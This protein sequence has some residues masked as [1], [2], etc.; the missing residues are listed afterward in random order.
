MGS[1][2]CTHE[3]WNM[4]LQNMALFNVELNIGGKSLFLLDADKGKINPIPWDFLPSSDQ[5]KRN[6]PKM[7]GLIL[8]VVGFWRLVEL[9]L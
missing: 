5:T 3:Q 2:A 4:S 8:M 9:R 1:G 7:M 6:N